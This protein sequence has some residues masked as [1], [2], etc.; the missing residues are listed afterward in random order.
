MPTAKSFDGV[1]IFYEIKGE[2][3]PLILLGSCGVTIDYWKYQE[4]LSSKYKLV[5][6]DVAGIGKS[7]RNRKEYIT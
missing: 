4:P 2:G 3:N 1:D 5:M 6:I 7:G